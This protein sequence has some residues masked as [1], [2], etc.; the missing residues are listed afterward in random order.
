MMTKHEMTQA[1]NRL[2]AALGDHHGLKLKHTTALAL[3][4]STLG[5]PNAN[6]MLASAD[7]VP[8]DE[9]K[10]AIEN[11][12]PY[13]ISWIWTY[14]EH[15]FSS[16]A[17]LTPDEAMRLECTLDNIA[18]EYSI[19]DVLVAPDSRDP[20][21]DLV[22]FVKGELVDAFDHDEKVALLINGLLEAP[23]EKNWQ[24]SFAEILETADPVTLSRIR[25]YLYS[26]AA[27]YA[28]ERLYL[29]ELAAYRFILDDSVYMPLRDL[30]S[31]CPDMD[32][33]E[34]GAMVNAA[35]E[36]SRAE[37][38]FVPAASSEETEE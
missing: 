29:D 25:T 14:A 34:A 4:A 30:I 35:M 3:L 26:C 27:T 37:T 32:P 38:P 36:K 24:A 28:G 33:K 1:A 19:E 7:A 12:K 17:L 5:Y 15:G 31:S 22:S 10:P 9:A 16:G 6:T 8:A 2:A 23:A 13:T 11:R 18:S 21:P 20:F